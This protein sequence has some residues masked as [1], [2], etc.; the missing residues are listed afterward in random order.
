MKYRHRIKYIE[1]DGELWPADFS[2]DFPYVGYFLEINNAEDG[3]NFWHCIKQL[4][5]FMLKK[6]R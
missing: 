4:Q 3:Q 6:E 5:F 2:A 1:K